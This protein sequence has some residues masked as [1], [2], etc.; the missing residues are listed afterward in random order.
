MMEQHFDTATLSCWLQVGQLWAH[1]FSLSLIKIQTTLGT[2][3]RTLSK[4]DV[5][6]LPLKRFFSTGWLQ[7]IS[8]QEFSREQITVKSSKTTVM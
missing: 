7:M 3:L 1:D 6:L 4:G 8:C 2:S 5:I